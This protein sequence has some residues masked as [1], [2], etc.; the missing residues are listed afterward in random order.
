MPNELPWPTVLDFLFFENKG[1]KAAS[2]HE[3]RPGRRATHAG[4]SKA[5]GEGAAQAASK[6]QL[7]A[8][9]GSAQARRAARARVCQARS[10]ERRYRAPA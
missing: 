10:E 8:T 1:G 6:A 5:S 2:E 7:E 4:A 9:H 3:A